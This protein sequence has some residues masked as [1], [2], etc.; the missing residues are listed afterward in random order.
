MPSILVIEG[1]NEGDYYPLGRRTLVVGR[2][3]KCPIQLVDDLVSRKHLQIRFE[4]PRTYYALDMKS[5]NGVI[6][7]G[8]AVTVDTRLADGDVI[9]LGSS[10]LLFSDREFPDRDSAWAAYKQAGQRGKSTLVR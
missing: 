6:V 5:A 7:N 1:P 3:E 9:E 2:D 4:E 8:H 10:Q